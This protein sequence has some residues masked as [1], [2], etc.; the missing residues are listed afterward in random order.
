MV[1]A[2]FQSYWAA[3]FTAFTLDNY[4]N[5]FTRGLLVSAFKNSMFLAVVGAF[6]ATALT[7]TVAYVVQRT[8]AP[9]R[10]MLDLMST[11][12]IAIPGIVLGVA[13]LWAWIRVPLPIYG[14]IDRKSKRL[15]SS[16]YCEH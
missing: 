9:G 10:A 11:I 5:V 14:T 13:L 7:I 3:Q 8:R 6:I 15:K 2:S 12:S 16:H 1:M 4:R